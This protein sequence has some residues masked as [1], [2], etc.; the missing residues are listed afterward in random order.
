MDKDILK[1]KLLD[2]LDCL[3]N[4]L[5]H[6]GLAHI[7]NVRNEYVSCGFAES[8][9]KDSI[10]V[11]LN[12]DLNVKVWSRNDSINDIYDL[13]RYQMGCSFREA[14]DMIAN[15]CNVDGAN[16]KI[17]KIDMLKY[18][19]KKG[20]KK[21]RPT[22]KVLSEKVMDGFVDGEVKIFSDDGIDYE[23]QQYF[24]VK[25]DTID[26]RV[27]FPIR[28]F[29]G[30]L[31]TVKG[32][33]LDEDYSEKGIPKYLYYHRFDGRYFLYGYYENYF[34]ILDSDELIVVEGEKSVMVLHGMGYNNVVAT[35]KKRISEEQAEEINKLNKRVVLAYDNDVS[36]EEIEKECE[37]LNGEVY[38]IRDKFGLLG[39]KDSPV[40]RGASVWQ[41]LYY[42]K[43]RYK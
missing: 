37:K 40:D 1:I 23:T 43:V 4:L 17:K 26:N 38:Y 42:N 2:N 15:I 33:T 14:I 28:D 16:S 18:V 11:F 7:R 3:E 32:R 20:I 25:F 29:N 36:I 41:I 24:G 30:N 31:L 13:I 35:S 39:K 5:E 34:D 19:I 12:K 10:Q 8:K 21:E 9:R 27:V 22:F 6:I